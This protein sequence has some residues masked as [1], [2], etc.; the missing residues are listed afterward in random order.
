MMVSLFLTLLF[1]S[2][3]ISLLLYLRTNQDI[4]LV[5]AFFCGIIFLIWSLVVAHWSVHLVSLL[6]LLCLRIPFFNPQVIEVYEE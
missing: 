1:L 5:L 2:T 4:H 3:F 6:A